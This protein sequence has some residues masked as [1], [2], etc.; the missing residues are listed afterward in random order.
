MTN[1][2]EGFIVR[3]LEVAYDLLYRLK[4]ALG[5]RPKVRMLY[6]EV[7]HRC[8]ACCPTCYTCAGQEKHDALSLEEQ[9]SVVRQARQLGARA[10]SLSG[11]GEPLLYRDLFNLIEFIG[12]QEMQV[13]MFTNGTTIDARC[14]DFLIGH[15]VITYFKLFSL[16]PDTCD[17]MMGKEKAYDWVTYSYQNDGTIREARIPNGLKCL[18]DAQATAG[19]TGLVRAES[20][21]T[22]M[23]RHTLPEVARLCKDMNLILHLETPV[24]AGR[25]IENY[26]QIALTD[27]EYVALYRE[28]VAILGED[29]FNELR[30]HPCPVERNP[31]V[32]TNGDIGLCNSRPARI[33]NVRD[34]PLQTLFYRAQILKQ[35]EDRRLTARDSDSRYFRTCPARRYYQTKHGIRCHY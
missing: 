22:K 32:W 26:A 11:S 35:R 8:N 31:V 30:A 7:T 3:L 34:F 24:F 21:I 9:K 20:L 13:V 10:V 6:L 1:R 28:L 12:Q 33:G 23:N 25:A 27:R 14:A 18:L 16:D 15:Q 29:Y 17:R 4:L 5:K 19:T 2:Q